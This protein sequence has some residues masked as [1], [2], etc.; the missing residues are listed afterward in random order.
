MSFIHNSCILWFTLDLGNGKFTVTDVMVK[1]E[2]VLHLQ[3]PVVSRSYMAQI[4][5]PSPWRENTHNNCTEVVGARTSYL[6]LQSR[7]P[8]LLHLPVLWNEQFWPSDHTHRPHG[9]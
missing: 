1:I 5:V 7:C 3:K 4:R 2:R 8:C 6:R 9:Y